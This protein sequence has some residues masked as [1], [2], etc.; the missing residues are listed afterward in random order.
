MKIAIPAAMLLVGVWCTTATIG[1]P[2]TLVHEGATS[3][4]ILVDAEAQAE[5]VTLS[6]AKK[7]IPSKRYHEWKAANDLAVYIE[8]MTG[9]RPQIVT[10]ATAIQAALKGDAPALVVGELA[11]RTEPALRQILN[12]T[13][14]PAKVF[15]SDAIALRRAG[16]KVYLAGSNDRSHYFAVAKL[17]RDWGC[18]W[19][20]PTEFG[21][22]IPERRELTLDQLDV[23]YA[24]PFEKRSYWVTLGGSEEGMADF[25]LR[26]FMSGKR[27]AT[28]QF[29]WGALKPLIP[30]GGTIAQVPLTAPETASHVA[31][32][33]DAPFAKGGAIV[34]SAANAIHVS[35][36]D[37]DRALSAGLQDKYFQSPVMSDALWSFYNQVA[38]LL[39][40][41]HPKSTSTL[42][43]RADANFTLPPQQSLAANDLL[44]LDLVPQDIDP[45]HA[46]GDSRSPSKEEFFGIL[47]RWS[48]IMKGRVMIHDLDQ[49]MTIWRDLPNPSHHVFSK[50]VKRYRDLGILGTN[51]ESRSA[52]AS[53]FTN[54]YLRAQLLWNPDA[55]VNAL[56]DEFY[57]GFYGPLAAPMRDYWNA[58]F[59]A[60]EETVATE[61]EYYVIPAIYGRDLVETL[62]GH[63]AAAKKL[64]EPLRNDPRAKRTL[65]RLEFTERS[66]AVIDLYTAMLQAGAAEG[67]Y[68]KASRVGRELLSARLALGEMNPIF[69][70]RV[71]GKGADLAEP[72]E[73][74]NPALLSG[75][76]WQYIELDE[77][78][79]G[80]KGKRV[81]NLPLEWAFRRDPRDTGLPRGF[82]RKPADLTYWD[83]NKAKFA[84]PESR[85]DYPTTEWETVR[86]DLYAQAQGVLHPDGQSFTGFLWYKTPVK[87][88]AAEAAAAARIRFPG[89]FGEAWLYVN[90][91][92]VEHR[93]QHQ[94]WWNN[95]YRFDW[96]ADLVGKLKPGENDITLRVRN[97]HHQ[98]GLFRRPFLYQPTSQD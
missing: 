62:R 20:L 82:A 53:T 14:R 18:R 39:K 76:V 19:Y 80:T 10:D 1:A 22:V 64:A 2:L 56:L 88:S 46:F 71:T 30:E 29:L 90:G 67:D 50:D 12:K 72:K 28:S 98:G 75:E 84:K 40:E 65:E 9:A 68:P 61:H 83:E 4:V 31:N 96:D 95:S 57:A 89:L 7:E 49:S 78:T 26:N 48:A 52:F 93:V 51:T 38:A 24:P 59:K 86:T 16:S 15:D 43:I 94:M 54:L 41:R 63:L 70:T 45:S 6:K 77:L 85:K 44:L 47:H 58:I 91:E 66:F 97:T 33:L 79:N 81:G 36:V 25:Q 21:E 13:A 37:A 32:K 11:T 5:A 23:A 73:G 69:T 27:E 17:L 34:L 74:A 3:T 92:L 42:E 60:W 8:K 55:D 87:L 35:T